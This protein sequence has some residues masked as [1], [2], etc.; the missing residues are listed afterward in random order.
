MAQGGWRETHSGDKNPKPSER[1]G[2]SSGSGSSAC[3]LLRECYFN[4][5]V[6]AQP[7]SQSSARQST[8]SLVRSSAKGDFCRFTLHG[9]D[10][11]GAGA[12]EQPVTGGLEWALSS[13]QETK[14]AMKPASVRLQS[15]GGVA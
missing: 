8:P 10:V 9:L 12:W 15:R 3:L 13:G 2:I 4:P 5:E 7:T 14:E 1:A 11:R 6:P